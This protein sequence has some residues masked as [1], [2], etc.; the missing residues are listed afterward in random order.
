MLSEAAIQQYLDR[1]ARLSKLDYIERNSK[2]SN[3]CGFTCNRRSINNISFTCP[4]SKIPCKS[5]VWPLRPEGKFKIDGAKA[6]VDCVATYVLDALRNI[7]SLSE[8]ALNRRRSTKLFLRL[9]M[10]G[11]VTMTITPAATTQTT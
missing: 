11:V 8:R 6:F 7:F 1:F 4:V 5:D 10:M 9:I 3:A 2:T